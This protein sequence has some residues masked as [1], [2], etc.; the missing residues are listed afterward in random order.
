MGVEKDLNS[1]IVRH[2][3]YR[4]LGKRVS[5]GKEESP[6]RD[7]YRPPLETD[8]ISVILGNQP[9]ELIN[10]ERKYTHNELK[11]SNILHKKK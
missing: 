2:E 7:E 10:F 8:D 9:S 5:K 6:G 1:M 11:S 4:D 3:T